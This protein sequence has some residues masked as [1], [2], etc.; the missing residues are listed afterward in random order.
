[1]RALVILQENI[2]DE[3][4][5]AEYRKLVMPTLAAFEAKFVVRGGQS[6]VIEGTWPFQRTVVLEFPSR[7]H[8]E[9]WYHSEAYQAIL[10]LRL[11]S[12]TCNAVI[13]D[14]VD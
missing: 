11:N 1:M 5:F 2:L 3:E 12:S 7:D 14:A 13:V 8:A 6:T 9:G 4:M 10:P